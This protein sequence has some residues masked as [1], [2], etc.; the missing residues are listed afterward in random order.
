MNLDL[1]PSR[2]PR[3]PQRCT[4][5]GARRRKARRRFFRRLPV[6]NAVV[7]FQVTRYGTL[8]PIYA[9]TGISD[10]VSRYA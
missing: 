1:I 5:Q 7:G 6:R 8:E 2:N 9:A 10:P 4:L 3:D